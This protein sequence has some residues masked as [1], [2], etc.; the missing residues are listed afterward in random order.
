MRHATRHPE[1][2]CWEF[3]CGLHLA[4]RRRDDGD[5]VL[6]IPTPADHRSQSQSL[7]DRAELNLAMAW[8][9]GEP[10]GGSAGSK[11][12]LRACLRKCLQRIAALW[13]RTRDSG[14]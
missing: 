10:E 3:P 8:S 5:W 7:D 2:C 6:S 12:S 4:L 9:T 14:K 13:S 1:H 11:I